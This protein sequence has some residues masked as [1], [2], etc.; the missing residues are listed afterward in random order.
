MFQRSCGRMARAVLSV[1]V[2][3]LSAVPNGNAQSPTHFENMWQSGEPMTVTGLV[4]TVQSDDFA[5]KRSEQV[6]TIRDRRTGKSFTLRFD[7]QGPTGFRSGAIATV[8]GRAHGSEIYLQSDQTSPTGT[9]SSTGQPVVALT[10]DTGDQRTLVILT[11]F[12]DRAV[13]CSPTD[14]NNLMFND[15]VNGSTDALYRESSFGQVSFSGNVVGPYTINYS[16][17]DPCDTSAWA[18]AANAAAA[19]AVDVNAYSR[20]VYVMPSS[21]CPAA[22]IAEVGVKPSRAWVFACDIPDVY[23][24]ELGHNLGMQHASTEGSEY[25]DLSDFMG[26]GVGMLRQV[27]APHKV[28]MGW[29]PSSQVVTLTQD[30]VYNIAPAEA[31][32]T[33][34]GGPQ[35]LK[36]FKPDTG[37]YYYLSYRRAI[38]F[39]ANL[40]CCTYLDRLNV[41]RWSGGGT[42]PVL[43]ATLQDGETFTDSINGIS[44][45][46]VS[47]TD[48]YSSASVSL[49][50]GCGSA[51][52]ALTFTPQ[53]RTGTP[54]TAVTYDVAVANYD[55]GSCAPSTFMLSHT[56]P[57]GWLGSVSPGSLQISPGTTGHAT[58]TVTSASDAP[59]GAYGPAVSAVDANV[60]V[61]VAS[62]TAVYQVMAACGVNPAVNISP[63]TQSAAAGTKLNYSVTVTNRDLAG[64]PATTF[65]LTPECL[66]AGYRRSRLRH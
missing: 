12:T 43:L 48:P 15:P 63:A 6:H 64:C 45:T 11:N 25:G 20:R 19:L 53:S 14:V 62:A 1:T 66:A 9:A 56:L 47:H 27:S 54:G 65:N 36:V 37:A 40:V 50:A 7:G 52:P 17:T 39:D 35:A 3:L 23:A 13:S 42:K 33:T 16:S 4:T 5:N 61:H 49:G 10:A 34:A 28:D 8:K 44:V 2:V 59:V 31:D 58:L 22:G 21:S 30:G 55:S 29:L 32:P 18:N 38:G 60:P 57:P 24:H 26:M 51:S 46:Q 41:H